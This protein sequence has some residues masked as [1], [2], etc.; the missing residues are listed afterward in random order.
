MANGIA[1]VTRR[2]KGGFKWA[3][4]DQDGVWHR[5]DPPQNWSDEDRDTASAGIESLGMQFHG[6]RSDL[7]IGRYHLIAD[8]PD[9]LVPFD[10]TRSDAIKDADA[11]LWLASSDGSPDSLLSLANRLGPLNLERALIEILAR[12]APELAETCT[13]VTDLNV[14]DRYLFV[15]ESALE[16]LSFTQAMR[17]KITS[18][19]WIMER[20]PI[21][22]VSQVNELQDHFG[23]GYRLL[24]SEEYQK[25]N[26][27][28]VAGNLRSFALAQFAL[29]L[30][31]EQTVRKCDECG[32]FFGIHPGGSR[33]DKKFCSDAC[34]MRAYRRRKAKKYSGSNQPA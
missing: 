12:D 13:A 17:T 31:G 20:D 29:S 9:G 7:E 10:R 34:R 2:P 11:Y 30:T 18:V 8:D 21:A 28:L 1:L 27:E 4:L 33:P 25:L 15:A 6:K 23:L 22:L 26:G 32:T 19:D 14:P 24:Y 3:Y 16:W 5:K